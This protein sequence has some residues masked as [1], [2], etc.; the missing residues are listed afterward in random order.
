M[1]R[2]L[3]VLFLSTYP[4]RACGIGTFAKDLTA[5]LRQNT[6]WI[7]PRI[8]AIDIDDDE[9]LEYGNEVVCRIP[10]DRRRAYSDLAEVVND[11]EYD[12]VCVQHEFGIFPGEWG[13][14]L[15]DF[16]AACRKPIVTTLHSV[17]PGCCDLPRRIVRTIVGK[18]RATVV[19]AEIAVDILRNDYGVSGGSVRVIPHGV[20][21][22]RPLGRA[23]AKKS[24]GFHSKA[25]ISTFGLLSR[26]KG[27]EHMVAAMPEIL[28]EHPN[29]VYCILG[30]TH[31]TVKKWEG[32]SYRRELERMVA[33]RGLQRHVRFADRFLT[34]EEL[35]VFLEATD[36]YVT[37][38][39]GADQITSGALARAAFFGKAIVSTPF[40]Y[41]KELLAGRRGRFAPFE[42]SEALG[43]EVAAVL[44]DDNLKTAMETRMREYSR[45]MTWEAVA[46]QYAT[47][48]VHA[49][50]GQQERVAAGRPGAAP[51]RRQWLPRTASTTNHTQGV[52]PRL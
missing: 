6:P 33:E 32:E 18:S 43:R 19:M 40:L 37:P 38:Y 23:A 21:A 17:I 8:A 45:R 7:A 24:L 41:A 46:S 12:L 39:L 13:K 5:S 36:V 30:R 44:S 52:E 3:Q 49:V 4:P 47:V 48:F 14:N 34:D 29:A 50:S 15:I 22:F 11:S 20:P 27:L 28:E 26:G 10:N 25:V 51:W 42:N 35:S 1:K 31:P 16:Y 2:T 9:H